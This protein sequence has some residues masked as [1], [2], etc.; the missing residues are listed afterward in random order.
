MYAFL[1]KN[2]NLRAKQ[3]HPSH[4]DTP[5]QSLSVW[6]SQT[7]VKQITFKLCDRKIFAEIKL[8]NFTQKEF[9]FLTFV[10]KKHNLPFTQTG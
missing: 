1:I 5:W 2:E 7:E 6:H 3:L 4:L 8:R 9:D 10:F